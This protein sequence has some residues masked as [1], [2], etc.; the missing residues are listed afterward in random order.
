APLAA[1]AT[2]YQDTKGNVIPGLSEDGWKAVAV[3]GTVRGMDEAL[4]RWG[5]LPRATVMAPAIR[6]ARDG[7]VL[8]PGDVMLLRTS[9]DGFRKDP[10]AAAIFLHPDGTPYAVGER[11]KQPDLAATLQRIS[12]AGPDAFYRGPVAAA[13]VAASGKGGGI[14]SS[15]DLEGYRTR[16]LPPITCSYHGTTVYT[17]PP[18]SGGG[19]ALC[20]MLGILDG[21]HLGELGLRSTAGVQR[22]VEAMRRAFAD[23]QNLG[24][25]AFVRNDVARLLSPDYAASVRAHTATDRATPSAELIPF[26]PVPHAASAEAMAK[27]GEGQQT[28]HFSIVDKDGRAVAVTYT[29]NAWFGAKVVAAGTG[30]V[31]NDEMDDFSSK[32]GAP[33]MFGIVGSAANAIAPGKTPLSS[34]SPTVLAKDGHAVMVIGSPGGS[35][36]PTITLESI[37][38][39]LD[40]HLDIAGAVNAPRIHEQ[41][42]PST[43]QAE[44][45]ALSAEVAAALQAMGYKIQPHESWGSAEGILVGGPSLAD[46]RPGVFGGLDL[47]HPGGAA[48]GE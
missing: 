4:R 5:T 15:A 25:P 11:L 36:I 31:M 6:L 7:F 26:D 46:R 18:P 34:M 17:A 14:L 9:T 44:H 38:G 16:V 23:R 19:V 1:T 2:M 48:I 40:G 33:N 20:E 30:V 47:R 39:V 29:L 12:D 24:D 13:I 3:P 32:P 42:E 45:G 43:V 35:R 22:Q 41:W 8:E 21:E 28:T 10:A 37:L 27:D